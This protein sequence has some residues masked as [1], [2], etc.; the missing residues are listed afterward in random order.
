MIL[1]FTD[2]GAAG[3]YTGQ[4]HAALAQLAPACR[5][6]DLISDAP[7]FAPVASAHLLASLVPA[8]PAQ[9]VFL[10]VVD[11]G[12]GTERRALVARAN[13]R[14]L[15]GPDNGLLD[16]ALG[17]AES[18]QR[19]EITWRPTLMSRTFHGRDLFAPVAAAIAR[20]NAIPEQWVVRLGLEPDPCPDL[21]EVIYIDAYGNA[22]TGLRAS[23]LVG[24]GPLTCRGHEFVRADTFSDVPQGGRLWFPNSNG[25]V[26]LAIHRGSAAGALGLKVGCAVESLG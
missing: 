15:V 6:I 4:V 9:T 17:R 8:F 7:Q 21:A 2:F 5:S 25:L 13:G 11:P 16:V 23:A 3:P 14:W 26:E 12:V 18:A 10:C 19:W 22:V 1:L 20:E 24:K